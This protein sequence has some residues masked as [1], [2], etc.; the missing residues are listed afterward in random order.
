MGVSPPRGGPSPSSMCAPWPVSI[1]PISTTVRCS[2]PGRDPTRTRRSPPRRRPCATEENAGF[3][4]SADLFD[5]AASVFGGAFS[6]REQRLRAVTSTFGLVLQQQVAWRDRLFVTAGLR[7][8]A[9]TRFHVD[10][11]ATGYPSLGLSGR[12]PVPSRGS[13]LTG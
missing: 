3:A 7:R 1:T 6:I 9:P 4:N 8:D 10:D 2:T 12:G 13:P 5:S 11:P